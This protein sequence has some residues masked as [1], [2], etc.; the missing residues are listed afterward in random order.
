MSL[1]ALSRYKEYAALP[2]RILV[3]IHLI[4]G[5]QDNVFSGDRML[6]FEKFLAANGMIFPLFSAILSVYAQFISGILYVLGWKVRTAAIVMII[7]FLVAIV[8]VHLGDSYSNTF[9]AIVM[10]SGSVF[11]LLNGSGALA[12]DKLRF[13]ATTEKGRDL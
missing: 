7:N 6:E 8:L 3:G 13:K 11:L 1:Q 4:A 5:T 10:L 9:P 2:I 12:M